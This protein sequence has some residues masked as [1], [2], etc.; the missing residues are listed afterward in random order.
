MA[1]PV[2]RV[3]RCEAEHPGGVVRFLSD[4]LQLADG[5]TR[6]VETLTRVVKFN[7][8]FYGK[9][10][11]TRAML[12]AMVKNFKANTYGQEIMIDV[13]HRPSE[14]SAGTIRRLF[15]EGNKL[16]AEI[17]WTPYGVEAVT[18]RGFRYFSAEFHE[19]Y[20][21]PETGKEHGPTLLGAG[22]TTRPRV[23]RLDP[24]SLKLSFDVD[25]DD[26]LA[27]SPRVEK[28]LSEEIQTMW[29]E[30]I[31]KLRKQ[32]SE[33][34]KLR[35]DAVKQL[36]E[37]FENAVKGFSDEAQAKALMESFEATGQQLAEQLQNVPAEQTIK[38]D[39][40]SL[41]GVVAGGEHK[42]LSED[43]V[44]KLMADMQ[45]ADDKKKKEL[46]ETRD[47]LVK[48]F[49]DAIDNAEGLKQL[50]EEQRNE[51]KEASDL[52]TADMT[53]EQAKKLAEHQIKLG[54]RMAVSQQLGGVGY[55]VQGNPHISLDES[56]A[57]NELQETV[58]RRLG[59]AE[60][61]DS[62]R[63]AATG[64]Q[65]QEENKKLAEKVLADF[66]RE[67]APQLHAE[68]K[69]LSGGDGVVSDVDVP[70]S[71]ERTVIREALFGLM[72]LQVVDSGTLPFN[73]SYSIPYSYR[74]TTGAGRS[75]T[76]K[77]E[78]QAISRA[79]V[80]QTAETAYN[81]P[82]KLSF[83]VSD[84]LR[85]LTQARHLNWDAVAEN[86]QN[87]SRIV[88]EDMEQ[89][90]FNETLR[91]SDEYS[92]TA[93]TD[94]D[95]A[96]GDIDGSNNT[97]PLANFPVVRPRSVYDLQGNQVGSTT[98]AITVQYD[99]G[100][101]LTAIDEYDGTGTQS[102]GNYYKLDY[103]LGEI[104]I[105][106]ESG[107]VQVP[108][109]TDAIRVSY[110]YA[111]N[112]GKFDT[113]EGTTDTDIHWDGFLYRYGLRKSVIEDDRYHMVNFGTMSGTVKNQIEQARKFAANYRV[114]GT[115][116]N[117]DGNLGRIKDVA[118]F[119]TSAPGLW[120]GDQRVLLGERG[121]TR[122]RMTKPWQLGQ[123]QDQKDSNGRFT[124][125]KEAYG[126]QFLVLHTPTQLKRAY[127]SIVLYSSSGRV[128]RVA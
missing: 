81:I 40:S 22:L 118:N 63:Y 35:D 83:E 126:D 92:A 12:L 56:N 114:P 33:K 43:D 125:K 109:G 9:V 84:E 24:V 39:F 96:S 101:G 88:R 53:E 62:R 82:Q 93:V 100:S 5:Q 8:P 99:S 102:A 11:I 23:K 80:V 19:N 14:G 86:Q 16:R 25:E 120:M 27:V 123:L 66:D 51:L 32:L 13:S 1:R 103:N 85:Y 68:R 124:G 42:G 3:I 7:D 112:I 29:K 95:I 6:S 108:G 117:A 50:T 38:L 64:G 60:M 20:E 90:I 54:D 34:H 71:W 72:G 31:E 91:A 78:G 36:C 41:E 10:E 4:R 30:L 104:Q 127:T 73:S 55:Q 26:P 77:Y 110:S 44:K 17:D 87:A 113:D 111:T 47:N 70:V 21:D 58:D 74:D 89:M 46:Q 49:T 105:V 116:L 57:I 65:L 15:V 61:S 48:V 115:E 75:D 94:E 18:G 28:I 97:F 52:I 98:N 76:R 121:M 45:A 2:A 69:L 67:R 106:D 128:A 122:L 107:A 37:G 119:K 59:L 79:G